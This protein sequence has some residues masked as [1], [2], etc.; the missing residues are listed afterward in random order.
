VQGFSAHELAF[1]FIER[2][3]EIVRATY[4]LDYAY[5]G[6]YA[7]LLATCEYGYVPYLF[8]EDEEEWGALRMRKTTDNPVHEIEWFPL[9]PSSNCGSYLIPT[10]QPRWMSD[11]DQNS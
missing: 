3:P 9:P 10:P 8:S 7:T 1:R 5:V 6:W 11:G 4:R 2:F